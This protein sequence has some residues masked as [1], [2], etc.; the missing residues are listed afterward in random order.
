MATIQMSASPGAPNG[1]PA[2]F[3]PEPQAVLPALRAQTKRTK[4]DLHLLHA[5]PAPIQTFPLPAFYPNNPLSLVHLAYAW[6]NH[7]IFTPRQPAKVHQG[8]WSPQTGAVLVKDATSIRALWEQGFYGKGHLS[9]SEPEWFRQE[10]V[11]RGL[12]QAHVSHLNTAKRREERKAKK[13]ERAKAELE[14]LRQVQLQEAAVKKAQNEKAAAPPAAPVGPLE[15]L[16]LPNSL[17][18]ILE[19]PSLADTQTTDAGPSS[20]HTTANNGGPLNGSPASANVHK[21]PTSPPATP[22]RQPMRRQKSVRFSPEV[23]ST[24]V[25]LSLPP[26]PELAA[27]NGDGRSASSG[28]PTPPK[29]SALRALQSETSVETQQEQI[30]EML[31]ELIDKEHL[32]LTREE[33]FFLSFGLGALQVVDGESQKPIATRDLLE[34][35]RRYSYIPPQQGPVAQAL[36]PD[37]RFLL[38][39]VVYHHFRSLG[40]VPRGGIKFGVDWLLYFK[41]PA[42]DHAQYGIIIMPSY[43]HSYWKKHGQKSPEKDWAWFHRVSRTLANVLKTIVLAYVDIPPPSV[44]EEALERGVTDVMKLYTIREIIAKRFNPN[45]ERKS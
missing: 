6:V 21:Q 8:I 15:L 28:L 20:P 23:K 40:W 38:D 22:Q 12:M 24:T 25:D 33:A 16:A 2:I 34:L 19:R 43:S 5:L 29:E 17:P 45:R 11:K 18:Y 30:S 4:A 36:R 42:F 14:A 1:G 10:Q 3:N 9:R 26:S 13:W 31:G 44:F 37:D 27:L 35:F 39:Y 7:L 41:G 32:Q